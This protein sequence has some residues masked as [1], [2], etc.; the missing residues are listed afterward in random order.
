MS[1]PKKDLN[2]AAAACSPPLPKRART[3]AKKEDPTPEW[4]DRMIAYPITFDV[5]NY[6]N[7]EPA[8]SWAVNEFES[9]GF[10]SLFGPFPPIY[11]RLVRLFYQ[12]M[13]TKPNFPEVLFTTIDGFTITVTHSHIGHALHFKDVRP[14][15]HRYTALPP[16][17]DVTSM[18][19][20]MCAGRYT[21]AQPS[22]TRRSELPPDLWLVDHVFHANICVSGHKDQR[23]LP[24]LSALYSFHKGYW[25]SIPDLIWQEMFKFYDRVTTRKLSK[26]ADQAL[27]F[28][29]FI[30]SLLR[31]QNFPIARTEEVDET[32]DTFGASR[33]NASVGKMTPKSPPLN[34]PLP[35]V[36]PSASSNSAAFQFTLVHYENLCHEL[37]SLRQDF[38]AFQAQYT[39]DVAETHSLLHALIASQQPPSDLS[40]ISSG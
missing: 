7:H 19:Q 21:G 1:R 11:P 35:P 28:P 5:E 37:H 12:N 6:F 33:W 18:I 39:I 27:P 23:R 38:T 30:T 10:Q 3:I 29:S 15:S 24:F 16:G 8:T 20:D 25:V 36:P 31:D 4:R 22:V 34:V 2:T 13:Y 26:C 40:D 14:L 9:R 32:I 17:L